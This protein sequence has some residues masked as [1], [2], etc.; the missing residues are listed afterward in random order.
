MMIF[1]TIKRF[2]R[3]IE[4]DI[5]SSHSLLVWGVFFVKKEKCFPFLKIRKEKHFHGIKA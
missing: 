1:I 2:E 5:C 4:R 3:E